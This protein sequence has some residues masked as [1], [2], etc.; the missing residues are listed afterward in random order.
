MK[1]ILYEHFH[2]ELDKA[3]KFIAEQDFESAWIALQRAH[4]LGQT[5]A[6]AHVIAHWNM[7]KLA[8][9]QRD[10]K[11]IA[12]QLLPTF[13][14]IP[15]TLLYG[16]KRYLRGGKANVNNSEKMTIPEDIQQILSQ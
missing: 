5:D 6:I 4:I 8:W 14:A 10:F 12:G 16:K 1:A 2:A 7:L 9:K 15:L 3:K 11:E 13:L